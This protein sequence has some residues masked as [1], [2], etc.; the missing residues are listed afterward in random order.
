ME[1]SELRR[2]Q[3]TLFI[4][5][6]GVITFGVWSIIKSIMY[7]AVDPLKYLQVGD[8]P[9]EY[10]LIIMAFVY[11]IIVLI[12]GV[13]MGLRI[14]VGLSARAEAR[15]KKKSRAYIVVAVLMAVAN[16]LLF[17]G[18]FLLAVLNPGAYSGNI[19]DTLVSAIVDITAQITLI[20]LIFTA[21]NVQRLRKLLSL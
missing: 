16:L 5:G 6:G 21:R 13:D 9:E 10:R 11:G 4:L 3:N 14:Y 8:I 20:E 17:L 1:E 2:G 12:I 15:G 18:A 7:V 19:L